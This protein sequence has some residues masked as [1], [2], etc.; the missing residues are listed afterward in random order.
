MLK[1]AWVPGIPVRFVSRDGKK[2]L[3]Q[4]WIKMVNTSEGEWQ[5]NGEHVWKDVPLMIEGESD[6]T[7]WS[8]DDV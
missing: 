6:P 7:Y 8:K 2:M 1:P 5:N 4:V 3:Q